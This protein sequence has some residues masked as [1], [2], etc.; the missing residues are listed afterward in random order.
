MK[1]NV[2]PPTSYLPFCHYT[3]LLP[4][5]IPSVFCQENK[6]ERIGLATYGLRPS[7][8]SPFGSVSCSVSNSVSSGGGGGG[9]GSGN[10]R[11]CF[12]TVAESAAIINL[13]LFRD[14]VIFLW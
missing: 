13:N 9:G 4:L 11:G 14:M 7:G 8:L 1:S 6:K 3:S 12:S 10:D 2:L 5:Y